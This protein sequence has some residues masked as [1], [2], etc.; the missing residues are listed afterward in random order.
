[1]AGRVQTVGTERVGGGLALN[2]IWFSLWTDHTAINLFSAGGS[3]M[4]GAS[5][6]QSG[7]RGTFAAGFNYVPD[8]MRFSYPSILKATA[9]SGSIYLGASAWTRDGVAEGYGR[10]ENLGVWF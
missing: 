5:L 6:G 1:D 9:A 8:G 2:D 4:P 3:L 10:A 7:T